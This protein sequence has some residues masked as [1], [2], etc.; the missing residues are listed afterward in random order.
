[1]VFM[2]EWLKCA[3]NVKDFNSLAVLH[4]EDKKIYIEQFKLSSLLS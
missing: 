1:M 3:G 4:K 2:L